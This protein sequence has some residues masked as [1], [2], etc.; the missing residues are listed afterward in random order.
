MTSWKARNLAISWFI[1]DGRFKWK[2]IS[3]ETCKS[4]LSCWR[5]SIYS[6]AK[7][8]PSSSPGRC[9][10]EKTSLLN[11]QTC[12]SCS[13]FKSL[14]TN[15]R[16]L[17]QRGSVLICPWWKSMRSATNSTLKGFGI[18]VVE[19]YRK[20][21]RDITSGSAGNTWQQQRTTG[22]GGRRCHE[23]RHWPRQDKLPRLAN[24]PGDHLG[25]SGRWWDWRKMRKW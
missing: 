14:E 11:P 4:W 8:F 16:I 18:D 25:D 19:D 24:Q 20:D 17:L 1:V 5:F 6:S 23:G 2:K 21:D 22:W 9:L 13:N 7:T 3:F 15:L 12:E 10:F